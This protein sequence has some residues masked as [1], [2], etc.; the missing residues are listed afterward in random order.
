MTARHPEKNVE[1]FT[2]SVISKL[3]T[4]V[5]VVASVPANANASKKSSTESV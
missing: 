2:D 5:F 4:V 3:L 1:W